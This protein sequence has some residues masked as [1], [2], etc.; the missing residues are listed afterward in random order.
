MPKRKFNQ[1]WLFLTSELPKFKSLVWI[2]INTCDRNSNF[3]TMCELLVADTSLL[4]HG[5]LLWSWKRKES[6]CVVLKDWKIRDSWMTF[7]FL[8][9][10]KMIKISKF[11]ET[12][13]KTKVLLR[14][15]VDFFSWF[16]H[17][18]EIFSS[19]DTTKF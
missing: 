10:L 7:F 4:L 1:F 17:H 14:S 2:E 11:Y 16:S 9:T 18:Q 15:F 19:H 13:W 8:C 3:A 6:F 12:K 5:W